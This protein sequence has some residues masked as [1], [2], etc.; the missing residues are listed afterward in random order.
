MIIGCEYLE[1]TDRNADQVQENMLEPIFQL[2]L[3]IETAPKYNKKKYGH[4]VVLL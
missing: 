2:P 4:N 3:E 1:Q